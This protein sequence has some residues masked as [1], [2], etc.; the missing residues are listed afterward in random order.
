MHQRCRPSFICW[1]AS[2]YKVNAFLELSSDVWCKHYVYNLEVFLVFQDSAFEPQ[3]Y[4]RELV[5]GGADV[6]PDIA[7][8]RIFAARLHFI[9]TSKPDVN[10]LLN[11]QANLLN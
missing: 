7:V 1:Y 2:K 11:I 5:G 8:A 4:H 3:L 10:F 6:I 9:F